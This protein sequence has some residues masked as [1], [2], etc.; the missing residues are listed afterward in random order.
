MYT[1]K[2]RSALFA[3]SFLLMSS[4]AVQTLAQAQNKLIESTDPAAR[5]K[6]YEEH[7]AMRE[8]SPFK[9]LKWRFIGP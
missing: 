4:I 7:M 3:L 1:S 9:Q 2:R 6:W 8:K 5:L